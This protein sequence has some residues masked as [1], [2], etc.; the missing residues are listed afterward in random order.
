MRHHRSTIMTATAVFWGLVF[1]SAALSGCSATQLEERSFPMAALVDDK[2]GQVVF[3]YGVSALSLKDDTDREVAKVNVPMTSGACCAESL[4]AYEWEMS[5]KA[6]CS[7]LKVLVLGEQ[8]LQDKKAFNDMLDTMEESDLYPRNTYVCVTKDVSVLFE[9]EENLPQD[10]GTYLELCL[11]NHESDRQ[12]RHENLGKL[13]DERRN[14]RKA[15][16]LPCLQVEEGAIVLSDPVSVDFR[17][18]G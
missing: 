6:D 8:L 7:H 16:E 10:L 15:V 12:I 17:W 3:A 5:K 14:R 1:C 13:L 11:Q 18:E 2:D 9:T 4:A